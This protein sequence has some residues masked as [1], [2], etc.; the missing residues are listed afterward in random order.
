[1][2]RPVTAGADEP[3]EGAQPRQHRLRRPTWWHGRGRHARRGPERVARARSWSASAPLSLP[4]S[5]DSASTDATSA[6]NSDPITTTNA[7]TVIDD[8]SHGR[9]PRRE[10][11]ELELAAD[12][13]G[14]RARTR[15]WRASALGRRRSPAEDEHDPR[16]DRHGRQQRAGIGDAGCGG[17]P[18]DGSYGNRVSDRRSGAAVRPTRRHV[19]RR[20]DAAP[21]HGVPV[22]LV[23]DDLAQVPHPVRA[24]AAWAGA[25]S[26]TGG[27]CPSRRRPRRST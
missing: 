11:H 19:A 9:R 7:T 8:A 13:G 1:M 24:S 21:R 20:L 10:E 15:W 5:A 16:Q 14:E 18:S 22:G 25:R 4:I 27:A 23:E 6:A 12:D 17:R 3:E 2:A 26:R